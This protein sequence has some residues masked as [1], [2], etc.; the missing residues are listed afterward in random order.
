MY[1][2]IPS[3]DALVNTPLLAQWSRRVPRPVVVSAARE[4]LGALR[5]AIARNAL[6]GHSFELHDLARGVATRLEAELRPP[7]TGAINATGIILH[8]GLGR[9]PLAEEAVAALSD[10]A[11]NYSPVEL[12][13]KTGE[14][15]HRAEVVRKLL[16]EL[17]GAES[18]T[19][20]NNNA[21]A[22]MLVL[23]ALARGK[24]VIVSRGELIEI[25]G[26][27]RL[28][29]VMVESGA[30][31]S[32]VGTTNRTHL[33]DYEGA[34]DDSTGALFKVHTSNYRVEGFTAEAGI[35]QLVQL[36]KR[37]NLPVIHDTGSG[38]LRKMNHPPLADEPD[39]A[40]SIAAGADVVLFSGDKLLGG[41]QCGIIVGRRQ[42]IEPIERHRLMRAFR[43]DK[44]TLAALGATL[45]LHRDPALARARLPIYRMLDATIDSLKQRARTISEALPRVEAVVAPTDS[46]FGGGSIPTKR[47][48]S[49]AIKL[50]GADEAAVAHRLRSGTPPVVGRVQHGALWL[51]LRTVFPS[52][53]QQLIDALRVAL[54]GGDNGPIISNY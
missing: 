36:G 21:A 26:S 30:L 46:Y 3:V 10:V 42:W 5:D 44:L 16:C 4:V 35:E 45:Q 12:D 13:L 7:L 22:T 25:G 24:S 33:R 54:A 53:D 50:T 51:D 15:G 38:L 20:V 9:A 29:D 28:P 49:I 52:Q 48:P 37:H 19:V 27:F 14:R 47:L 1:E 17:T 23:A 18:A 34:I 8:T 32:E 2:R 11:A 41:P 39:A 43:V 40:A 6:N 31:L